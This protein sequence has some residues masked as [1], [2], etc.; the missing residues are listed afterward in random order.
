M[1]KK[2][3]YFL[4][5]IV[6]VGGLVY[7]FK[8]WKKSGAATEEKGAKKFAYIMRGPL[9]VTVNATGVIEPNFVVEVKSKAGGEVIKLPYEEGD[10]V[11]KGDL[12]IELNPV[13]EQRNLDKA[14]TN[15]QQAEADL[16]ISKKNYEIAVANYENYKMTAEY[17][18]QSA[19]ASLEDAKQKYNRNVILHKEKLIPDDQLE[20]LKKNLISAQSQYDKS[21]ADSY[22][23]IIKEKNIAVSAENI[24]NSQANAVKANL[25]F[26]DAQERKNE[27]KI[28]SPMNGVVLSRSVSEGQIISSATSNV[29]GGTLLMKIADMSDLYLIANIDESD[30]GQIKNGQTATI[31]VDAFKDKKFSGEVER[32]KPLGVESSN[33][34]IFQVKIK[35][36]DKNKHLLLSGMTANVEILIDEKEDILYASVQAVKS[37]RGTNGIFKPNGDKP[38]FIKVET[39]LTNGE[40]IEVISDEIAEGDTILL[41]SPQ[42]NSQKKQQ[43]SLFGMSGGGR[44]GGR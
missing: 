17:S 32:I 41:D 12:L 7:Y 5:F 9:S 11:K 14:K 2:I 18:V 20:T 44:R 8:F 1:K 37:R 27:T 23:T 3:F 25:A 31:T 30:I 42:K 13:D 35:I 6:I 24:K 28:Y 40:V 4:I 22:A 34:T 10:E 15:V 36:S 39:G 19:R 21:I 38:K 26:A 43:A 33:I 29:G 16:A